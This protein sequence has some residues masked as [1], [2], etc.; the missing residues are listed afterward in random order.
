MNEKNSKQR[1]VF[2]KTAAISGACVL[3]GGLIATLLEESDSDA[4]TQGGD[5]KDEKITIDISKEPQLQSIPSA[6]KLTLK[7]INNGKSILI[8]RNGEN[9]F[10]VFAA[11]CTHKNAELRL[12]K[13]GM[14]KCP[15]HGSLFKLDGSVVS[16]KAK[17]PLHKIA[18]LYD[19][20]KKILTVG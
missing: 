16:G 19:E 4:N 9:D 3:C 18:S 15:L 7:G 6:A 14:I 10:T 8:L 12:P 5:V 17:K 20:Q 1:R 11:Q 2:L 13:D